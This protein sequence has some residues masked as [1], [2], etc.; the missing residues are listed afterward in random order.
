MTEEE[1]ERVIK[2]LKTCITNAPSAAAFEKLQF[3]WLDS[4]IS[5]F[6]LDREVAI[7]KNP[8]CSV[9]MAATIDQTCR[10]AVHLASELWRL[11][12]S[13]LSNDI[14]LFNISYFQKVAVC[15]FATERGSG[16]LTGV[17]YIYG[18]NYEMLKSSCRK[19]GAPLVQQHVRANLNLLPVLAGYDTE[20]TVEI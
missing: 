4:A 11:Q 18:E 14:A 8:I 16:L 2:S 7:T 20:D 9:I 10:N 3:I 13:L 17:I 5:G 1:F 12:F 19:K 15:R 6:F